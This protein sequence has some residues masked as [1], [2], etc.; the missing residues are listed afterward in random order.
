MN[1]KEDL[2]LAVLELIAV[3]CV[4]FI[5]FEYGCTVAMAERGYSACGGEYLLLAFPMLYYAGKRTI[6]DLFADLREVRRGG[7]PWRKED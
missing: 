3:I 5:L 4:T 2:V 1:L 6:K 7:R